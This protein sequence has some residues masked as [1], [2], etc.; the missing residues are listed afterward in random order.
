MTYANDMT[1][2]DDT[3]IGAVPR[4]DALDLAGLG[5][6][7]A[8]IAELLAVSAADWRNEAAEIGRYFSG[9]GE[10]LPDEL[11]RELSALEER[12]ARA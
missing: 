7:D 4:R 8:T 9:Y 5:L 1:A 6:A 2:A 10:R 12:L 3:P 11:R